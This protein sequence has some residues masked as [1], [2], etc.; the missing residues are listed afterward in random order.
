MG[1]NQTLRVK[2]IGPKE[3][4]KELTKILLEVFPLVVTGPILKMRAH[5]LTCMQQVG[6]I[7]SVCL[8]ISK[9]RTIA[10]LSLH[11]REWWECARMD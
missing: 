4:I 1:K 8:Y 11:S 7:D 9:C 5:T 3:S 2:I 10:K 6:Y